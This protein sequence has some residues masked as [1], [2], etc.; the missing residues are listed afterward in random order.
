MVG[1]KARASIDNHACHSLPIPISLS[2]VRE[3]R[4][5]LSCTQLIGPHHAGPAASLCLKGRNNM[6]N[7]LKNTSS[8]IP[9][10]LTREGADYLELTRNS[11][12]SRSVGINASGSLVINYP[13]RKMGFAIACESSL[14]RF[15]AIDFEL[16]DSVT[17]YYPQPPLRYIAKPNKSGRTQVSTYTPDFLIVK[18]GGVFVVEVKSSKAISKLLAEKPWEWVKIGDDISNQPVRDHFSKI[19]ISH[20]VCIPDHSGKIRLANLSILDATIKSPW[21]LNQNELTSILKALKNRPFMTIKEASEI[22]GKNDV[23]G[24]IQLI[25]CGIVSCDISSELLE[26]PDNAYIFLDSIPIN[27]HSITKDTFFQTGMLGEISTDELA[28]ALKRLD[29]L[30]NTSKSQMTRNDYRLL[31]KITDG[32]KAGL[33]DIVALAPKLKKRGNRLPKISPIVYEFAKK[34]ISEN[35]F[36]ANNK[37]DC[38]LYYKYRVFASE[39]HPN[40]TPI[41]KVTFYRYLRKLNPV[42]VARAQKGK[43]AANQEKPACPAED[44]YIRH[45]IPFME[46]TMDHYEIDIFTEILG[47]GDYRITKRLNFSAMRDIASGAILSYYLDIK[48]PKKSNTAI[49]LRRCVKTWGCLPLSIRVDRGADFKSVFVD[50][51]LA[52][53]GISKVLSPASDPRFGAEIERFF[54]E[55]KNN[56]LAGRPGF[57]NAIQNRRGT[58]QKLQPESLARLSPIDLLR[59]ID[60]F[61]KIRNERPHGNRSKSPNRMIEEAKSAFRF[62]RIPV[63]LDDNFLA[64]TSVDLRNLSICR[65]RGIKVGSLYYWN[66]VM[67][68]RSSPRADVRLDPENPYKIYFYLKDRWLSAIAKGYEHFHALATDEQKMTESLWL[69][70]GGSIR[71][72]MIEEAHI[73]LAAA[74]I[75]FDEKMSERSSPVDLTED[76]IPLPTSMDVDID[77]ID[78]T[79]W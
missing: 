28:K 7:Q 42:E 20:I 27:Q 32:R 35:R 54:L 44:R 53:L 66:D 12:P 15:A 50:A 62:S 74:Q 52:H 41:S 67:A 56:W 21:E 30:N 69:L 19:G 77:D 13:S 61:I 63:T 6:E 79:D 4:T 76:D 29:R 26:H 75:S 48:S 78:L 24:I 18:N 31:R 58:D 37:E 3:I 65:V 73:K 8:E 1:A 5:V 38:P 25:A 59:E 64:D 51:L 49:L 43:R 22:I 60:C 72:S 57:V 17:E 34:F 45:I 11:P 68:S 39:F 47:Y 71:K 55:L 33:S 16:S 36:S 23:T 14:E 70:Q 2:I 9:H 40:H 10:G 46:A